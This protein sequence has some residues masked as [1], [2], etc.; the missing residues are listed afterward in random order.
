PPSLSQPPSLSLSLS[1][2]L[3][4]LHTPL[5]H[6]TPS[7]DAPPPKVAKPPESG[8]P[9]HQQA[10]PKTRQTRARLRTE[11]RTTP[12]RPASGL[13]LARLGLRRTSPA[14]LMTTYVKSA[15]AP[16][17]PPPRKWPSLPKVADQPPHPRPPP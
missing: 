1:V 11:S 14:P 3:L 9:P 5:S 16:G 13:G 17:S 15:L 6:P 2:P 10:P 7:H 12:D 8:Q 4:S